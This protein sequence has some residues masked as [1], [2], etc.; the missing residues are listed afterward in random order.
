MTG[1]RLRRQTASW[2]V[3]LGLLMALTSTAMAQSQ[4]ALSESVLS[5]QGLLTEPQQRTF[6]LIVEGEAIHNLEVVRRDLRDATT[7][8]VILG[9]SITVDPLTLEEVSGSQRFQV[10]ISGATRPGHYTGQLEF[11][12]DEQT[13]EAPLALDLEAT[14]EAVPD[15]AA[16]V[17]SQDLVLQVQQPWH[18][19]PF[20]GRPR[21]E[22]E[23]P[24]LAEV[25]PYLLQRGEGQADV[26]EA[27]VLTMRSTKG[28]TLPAGAVR[29]DTDTPFSLESGEA[30]PLQ[31]VVAGQNL[32][33]G[34]YSGTLMV[35]VRNQ[36]APLQLPIRVKLK[37]GWLLPLIVLAGGLALGY[38]LHWWKEEGKVSRD[39][40]NEIQKLAK[41]LKPGKKLQ[42]DV[43]DGALALLQEAVKLVDQ[44]APASE[45]REKYEAA[46]V[47]VNDAR[48]AADTLLTDTLEPLRKRVRAPGEG[49][50]MRGK[51][52]KELTLI[53]ERVKQG[54]YRSLGEAQKLL[55]DP[56]KG[57]QAEIA[58][59]QELEG[60]LAEVVD[61]EKREAATMTFAA[62]VEFK[63]MRRVLKEAGV[64]VGPPKPGL[65]FA[66]KRHEAAQSRADTFELSWKRKLL[67]SVP[68]A[69]AA[70][71][72]YLFTLVVGWVSIYVASDTF[73]ANPQ[74]YISLF[75]WGSVVETV[76][77][78]V[79]T[80]TGLKAIAPGAAGSGEGG[81]E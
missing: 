31:V 5:F 46:Q 56:S 62:Q 10:T 59:L 8:V 29:V 50:A 22:P 33:A 42:A 11:R 13:G 18:D 76:R 21:A 38:V 57:I 28:Q 30:K 74:D 65:D 79:I 58:Y 12:Y 37:H 2:L 36:S 52:E 44:G 27:A 41:E 72:A 66:P 51:L 43:R 1:A 17:N 49:Q 69:I 15:V 39:L 61:E 73:G 77:G 64:T 9:S 68:G 53:E 19:F 80:L 14:L 67:L 32:K 45:I 78:K 60:K 47:L 75:L 63:E 54:E 34:E 7:G 16:D 71:V 26:Q 40:M 6:T 48:E 25:A 55:V 20:I 3:L 70:I 23:A 24:V 81:G 35:T 4:V